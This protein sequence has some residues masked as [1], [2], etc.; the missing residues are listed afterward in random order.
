MHTRRE[1][2]LPMNYARAARFVVVM[3]QSFSKP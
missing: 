1:R 2:L 3:S